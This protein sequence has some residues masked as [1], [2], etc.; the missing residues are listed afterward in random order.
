MASAA[1]GHILAM[2]R[3][4]CL[5][6]LGS[7]C[8]AAAAVGLPAGQALNF[9]GLLRGRLEGKNAIQIS[10]QVNKQDC[11]SK[12]LATHFPFLGLTIRNSAKQTMTARR[13][14]LPTTRYTL[15]L[16]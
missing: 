7:S 8:G 10:K 15:S 16:L 6:L 14:E 4:G 2:T 12:L 1:P 13:N 9:E 11:Q 3:S 5:H